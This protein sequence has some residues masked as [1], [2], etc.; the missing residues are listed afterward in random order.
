MLGTLFAL[1]S[2]VCSVIILV[3]AF[4]NAVWKGLVSLLC[5]VY[6]LYYAFAEFKHEKKTLILVVWLVS[7]VLGGG[8]TFWQ[9]LGNLR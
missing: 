7:A 9:S 2:L 3:H 5:F 6:L 1:V 4:Q 8:F